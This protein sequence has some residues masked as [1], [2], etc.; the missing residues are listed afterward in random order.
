[1]PCPP[2]L[3]RPHLSL[4][5][6]QKV[7][8]LARPA[9]GAVEKNWH[10]VSPVIA[11]SAKQHMCCQSKSVEPTVVKVYFLQERGPT[12]K[13]M[14]YPIFNFL[15]KRKGD[16]LDGPQ[17]AEF[18]DFWSLVYLKLFLFSL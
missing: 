11:P 18:D 12:W 4:D 3:I 6:F 7:G 17:Q 15:G 1:M 8:L 16:G 5:S 14:K 2:L 9:G 10:L 13:I